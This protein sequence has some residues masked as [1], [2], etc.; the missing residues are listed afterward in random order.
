MIINATPWR[1]IA[2][3]IRINQTII[4]LIQGNIARQDVDAIVNEW[5]STAVGDG[6]L[7]GSIRA[8]GG[9]ELLAA[10][11]AIGAVG[12]GE[13]RIVP[14]YQL[15]A[16]Y[17]IHTRGPFYTPARHPLSWDEEDDRG[18]IA[19]QDPLLLA[20]TYRN[21]LEL[22][23]QHGLASIATP[24]ISTHFG[25]YPPAEAAE[26][27]LATVSAFVRQNN[28]LKLVRFVLWNKHTL[29]AFIQAATAS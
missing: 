18:A 11:R 7:D 24:A 20:Q 19:A 25:A 10:S 14:G 4:E 3:H 16:R 17:L 2:M 15:Q 5:H 29:E 26:I 12:V 28:D 23:A 13:V 22:A 6:G 21:C 8:A 27:A 1:I 9:P